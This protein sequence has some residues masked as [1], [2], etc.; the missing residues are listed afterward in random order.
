M[1]LEKH[2]YLNQLNKKHHMNKIILA[3]ASPRRK[4]LLM[5]EG[6]DFIID[7]SS[8]DE[9]MD[10]SLGIEERI[11]KLAKDKAEP[12][13]HKYPDDVVIGADTVVYLDGEIIGKAKDEQDAYAIHAKMSNK[14]HTV[15]TGVAIYIKNELI[16]FT[17]YT[18]VY[19]KDTTSMIKDYIESNDWVGKAGAYAIQGKADIFVD[20]IEGDINTVIGLPVKKVLEVLKEHG[21]I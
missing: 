19:F 8:I 12:I 7:A 21:V 15:Y 9:T 18:D 1:F 20:H 6:I 14:M 16:T 5:N 10:M 11:A 17:D 3:S 2:Y 4:E 13:H